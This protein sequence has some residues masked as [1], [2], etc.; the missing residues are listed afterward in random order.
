[1]TESLCMEFLIF[2]KWIFRFYNDL[3][4]ASERYNGNLFVCFGRALILC[5][6][7][8]GMIS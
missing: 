5:N 3:V 7:S 8:R 1:M 4:F 2:V 6:N